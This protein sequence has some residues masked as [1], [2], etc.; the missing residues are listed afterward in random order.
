MFFREKSMLQ[1]IGMLGPCILKHLKWGKY[2]IKGFKNALTMEITIQK[3]RHYCSRWIIFLVITFL[4]AAAYLV[5]FFRNCLKSWCITKVTFN[6]KANLLNYVD[7][8]S[9]PRPLARVFFLNNECLI[10][11]QKLIKM[12]RLKPL[13]L[14]SNLNK[15]FKKK[16][17]HV[18][19]YKTI[20]QKLIFD[21]FLSPSGPPP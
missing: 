15:G 5:S 14:N 9:R 13:W 12:T 17:H 19:E 8:S 18:T 16:T 2:R 11:T 1:C 6:L 20:F 21:K 7:L 10:I 3:T 4:V